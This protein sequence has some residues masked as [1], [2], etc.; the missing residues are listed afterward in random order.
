MGLVMF[1]FIF[2]NDFFLS[3]LIKLRLIREEKEDEV[4]E[5]LGTYI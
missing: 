3:I 4:D 1:V 2:F 5:K